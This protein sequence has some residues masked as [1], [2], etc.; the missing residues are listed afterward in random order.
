MKLLIHSLLSLFL[1]FGSAAYSKE[2]IPTKEIKSVLNT[3]IA[4]FGCLV[5][6]KD[7]NIIRKN[8]AFIVLFTI[9]RTCSS[10]SNNWEPA[11][12]VMQ[13]NPNNNKMNIVPE[14]SFPSAILHGF[15]QHT[16]SIFL[17]GDTLW[18][19]GKEYN[20]GTKHDKGKGDALCCPS[21]NITSP[22]VLFRDLKDSKYK[23]ITVKNTGEWL[24]LTLN[25]N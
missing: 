14:K 11:L 19:T 13:L 2:T 24:W 15:P 22:F 12:A 17:K 21:I 9:D 7:K 6:L 10:G 20:W 3:Y 4:T 25:Q 23:D 1:L 5:D 18:F 8:K 16:D